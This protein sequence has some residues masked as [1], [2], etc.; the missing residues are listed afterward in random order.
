[1]TEVYR[2]Q[3][4]VALWTGVTGPAVSN[5]MRRWPHEVPVPDVEIR[6]ENSKDVLRG[7]ALDRK[8][9]WMKFAAARL[10]TPR[11]PGTS[12]RR[13]TAELIASQVETGEITEHTAIKL[14]T[15]LLGTA[16]VTTTTKGRS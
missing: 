12:T 3:A 7:W 10:V 13:R 1:M 6:N 9:E 2:G 11:G 15:S 5:W 8:D 14:L 16:P 4:D